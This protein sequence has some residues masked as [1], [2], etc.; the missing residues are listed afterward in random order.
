MLERGGAIVN[1]ASVGGLVVAPGISPYCASKHGVIG[2]S[3]SAALDYARGSDTGGT[4]D[5][6]DERQAA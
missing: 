3:K 1:T 4:P 6:R 2:L 5:G